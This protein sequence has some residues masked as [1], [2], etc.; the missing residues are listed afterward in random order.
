MRNT[1]HT[2]G[3]WTYNPM[4]VDWG[5]IRDTEG[6]LIAITKDNRVN[7][8]EM[9]KARHEKYDPYA[10]NAQLIAAAPDLLKALRGMVKEYY[11]FLEGEYGH[12]KDRV[13]SDLSQ[14]YYANLKM[15][16]SS[17][18]KAEGKPCTS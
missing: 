7:Q 10:A 15:A 1:Q 11:D 9:T 14:D 4:D 3:P 18:A 5:F 8:D 6:Q 12:D 2:P 13:N 17:I 16:L